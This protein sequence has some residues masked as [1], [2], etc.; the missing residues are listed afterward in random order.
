MKKLNLS[1]EKEIAI[2]EK[3]KITAVE[4]LF[5]KTLLILQEDSIEDYFCSYLESLHES[6]VNIKSII[7]SLQ[8][9]GIILKSY[10]VNNKGESFDPYAI[11]LNKTFVTDIYR[12]SFE[13][14]KELFEA[15]PQFGNIN[16]NLVPLRT[17]ARHFDSIEDAYF[18]YSKSIRWNNEKHNHIIE[19]VKWAKENNI[20]NCSL[21]SFI[22]NRG[23][24]DLE[25]LKDGNTVNINY[26]NIKLL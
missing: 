25:T 11:P 17:V 1:L 26:D 16:G 21:S 8:E 23:W 14:G 2:L 7:I 6:E 19:L 24:N 22:I 5:V 20:L 12:S 15:Y 4:L 3:Y 10:K 9:K 18:R 13:Q